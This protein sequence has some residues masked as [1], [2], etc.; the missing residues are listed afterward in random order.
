MHGTLEISLKCAYISCLSV[1]EAEQKTINKSHIVYGVAWS[2][3]G[4][5]SGTQVCVYEN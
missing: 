3:E 4:M 2:E 1:A 5:M